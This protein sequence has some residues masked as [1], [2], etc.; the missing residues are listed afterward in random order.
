MQYTPADVLNWKES[1][2]PFSQP[3]QKKLDNVKV[4][5]S[6]RRTR[7][8]IR[9]TLLTSP[10]LRCSPWMHQLQTSVDFSQVPFAAVFAFADSRDWG[11]DLQLLLDLV[12][13]DNGVFGT[14]KDPHDP[15][16]WLPERQLPVFFSNPDLLWQND[17][18]QPRFGQGA[19][20]EAAAAIYQLTTGHELQR[21]TGG[22]PSRATYEYASN[23]LNLA[24]E[25]DAAG[26]PGQVD[27]NA[28]AT[29]SFGGKVYMIGDNPES[30][31]AGA[32]AFGWESVLLN[33]TGVFRGEIEEARHTPTVVK[34]NVL[35][36]VRWALEREG[37]EI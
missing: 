4:S 36:A 32:N 27:M 7:L 26:R 3:I 23:L 8:P 2:W 24:V 31:I 19:L 6:P 1:V 33:R 13:A 14:L 16:V 22:K 17:F 15:S 5:P 30:D 9:P 12:R 11:R 35:E 20:Q 18:P 10:S 28:T 25:A 34:G 29:S 37:E 21:S